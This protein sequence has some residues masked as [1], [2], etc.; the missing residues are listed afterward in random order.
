MNV[1]IVGGGFGGVKAALELAKN[2]KNTITLISDDASLQYYP[3]LYSAA[4]GRSHRPA[5]IPL[6]T[7]FKH[8]PNVHVVRDY[9]VKLDP[10]TKQLSAKSGASYNYHTLILALGS[11]TSYFGIEGLKTYAYGY[12]HLAHRRAR[13]RWAQRQ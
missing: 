1:T 8:R 6:E 9:I 13:H 12:I 10:K 5:W 3:T 11:V 4:T 2:K 7:I